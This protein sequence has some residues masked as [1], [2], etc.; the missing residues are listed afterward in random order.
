MSNEF[1][2]QELVNFCFEQPDDRKITMSELVSSNSYG[3]LLVQFGKSKGYK[4]FLCSYYAMIDV[5]GDI[6]FSPCIEDR[7]KVESLIMNLDDYT[8]ITYIQVKN[9]LTYKGYSHVTNLG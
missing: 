2:F 6:L 4:D 3:C 9:Y 5:E 1:T 8:Y 7:S